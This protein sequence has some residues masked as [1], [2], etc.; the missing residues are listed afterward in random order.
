MM[1]SRILTF[2]LLGILTTGCT[3]V[4][5]NTVVT[6]YERLAAQ[7]AE[8]PG[9]QDRV[10]TMVDALQMRGLDAADTQAFLELARDALVGM[11]E[12]EFSFL[13]I[14]APSIHTR[15]AYG[16]I[17]MRAAIGA[18]PAGASI[19]SK[20]REATVA[21]CDEL[22][23]AEPKTWIDHD[24]CG[25]ARHFASIGQAMTAYTRSVRN[26]YPSVTERKKGG[27]A[28]PSLLTSVRVYCKYS[29]TSGEERVVPASSAGAEPEATGAA[30]DADSAIVGPAP[31]L[32][33]QQILPAGDLQQR[34]KTLSTCYQAFTRN[35]LHNYLGVESSS[36]V[37]SSGSSLEKLNDLPIDGE[38]KN[39][40]AAQGLRMLCVLKQA[41]AVAG[42]LQVD[43]TTGWPSKV[44]HT[45]EN[46]VKAWP[47]LGSRDDVSGACRT[48]SNR[49][50]AS[51]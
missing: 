5:L 37:S 6:D 26:L 48:I 18:G 46:Y 7:R 43:R 39:Y 28:D 33:G 17:G 20:L 31:N 13:S 8:S 32:Q 2:V 47:Y 22:E 12:D 1:N 35:V 49:G 45:I 29:D 41:D 4:R 11:Q 51:G 24:S 30:R 15:I 10:E 21:L 3:A 27:A 50:R 34:Q 25:Y 44:T 16:A 40:Y 14:N 23:K 9:G 42:R 38:T 19:G 36:G